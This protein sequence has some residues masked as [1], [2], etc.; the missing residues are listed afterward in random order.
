MKPLI[1]LDQNGQIS[2]IKVMCKK[3]DLAKNNEIIRQFLE[4]NTQDPSSRFTHTSSVSNPTQPSFSCYW[5]GN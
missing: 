1:T 3:K 4:Q 2:S 5:D